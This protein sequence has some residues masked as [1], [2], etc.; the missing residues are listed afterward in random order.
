MTTFVNHVIILVQ[1]VRMTLQGFLE[2]NIQQVEGVIFA[3]DSGTM[4][5]HVGS[6]IVHS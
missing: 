4:V 2:V 1:R 5:N 6:I 3:S